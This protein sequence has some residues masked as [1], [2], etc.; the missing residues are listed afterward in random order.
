MRRRAKTRETGRSSTA[1]AFFRA[2]LYGTVLLARTAQAGM[3]SPC[4][5]PIVLP[6][7]YVQVFLLPDRA[8]STL[9]SRGRQLATIL[10]RHVLFAALK[11]HSIGVEELTGDPSRCTFDAISHKVTSRMNPGQTAI[12]LSGRLF[13]QH[14]TIYRDST[15]RFFTV[16]QK[17]TIENDVTTWSVG[18][19]EA[20]K[21]TATIPQDPVMFTARAIPLSLLAPL[22][23]AQHKSRELHKEP[24]DASSSWPLPDDPDARYGFEVLE[25]KDDW[26][27]VR[28][29]PSGKDGWIA[30]HALASADELKGT[31]PELYFVDGLIGYEELAAATQLPTAEKQSLLAAVL[32]SLDRYLSFTSDRAESD[33]RALA[34]VVKGNAVLRAAGSEHSTEQ[35]QV[36]KRQYEEAATHA[37]NST[38]ARTF[39]LACSTTLCGRGACAGGPDAV[40]TQ[41]LAAIGKDPTS[42]ELVNNLNAF[43][44][45]VQS[46]TLQL[47]VPAHVVGEQRALIERAQSSLR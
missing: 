36:A 29:I 2:V 14:D 11:Y 5:D 19:G 44:A 10:Q 21:M 33:A 35:L 43:Y 42:R 20:G 3:I 41:Y 31:F 17:G 28:V 37:P 26:M 46:G 6:N 39:L 8:E 9:T 25:A 13:E 7:A 27:H 23:L 4:D 24:S 16:G 15:L 32:Q 22:E 12:F 30:A 40:R 18:G 45:A 1:K 38:L 34:A 47:N